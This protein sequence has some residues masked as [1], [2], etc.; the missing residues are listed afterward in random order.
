[1][2]NTFPVEAEPNI[3]LRI[4]RNVA[5]DPMNLVIFGATFVESVF[6]LSASSVSTEFYLTKGFLFGNMAYNTHKMIKYEDEVK[7]KQEELVKQDKRK[8]VVIRDGEVTNIDPCELVSG[9][10]VKI[11]TGMAAYADMV[12]VA[13]FVKMDHSSANGESL[14]VLRTVYDGTFVDTCLIRSGTSVLDGEGYARVLLVG[15][16][17]SKGR[18]GDAADVKATLDIA[19]DKLLS[20]VAA[21]IMSVTAVYVSLSYSKNELTS[22]LPCVLVACV[23]G[24]RAWDGLKIAAKAGECSGLISA[25]IP[26]GLSGI[27]NSI[28]ASGAEVRRQNEQLSRRGDFF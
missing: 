27:K 21:F 2:T 25:A 15:P 6:A 19:V 16:L 22:Q 4:V 3:L 7:S 18:V 20:L 13:G 23:K 12:L 8:A 17:S 5:E 28:F 9:D 24:K 1:M 10:L 11:E 14:P 26:E